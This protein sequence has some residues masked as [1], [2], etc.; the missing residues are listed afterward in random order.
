MRTLAEEVIARCLE[1]APVYG[2]A[3]RVTR[4]FLSSPMRRVHQMVDGWMREAGLEVSIDAAGNIRGLRG[5]AE[6]RLII[7]SIWIRCPTRALTT[8][9]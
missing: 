2:R 3:G 9:Y 5:S 8:G 7:A 4:T 1:L 6:R